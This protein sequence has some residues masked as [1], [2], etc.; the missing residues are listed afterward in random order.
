MNVL[1]INEHLILTTSKA[2]VRETLNENVQK[3]AFDYL[4][5]KAK[6]HSKVNDEVYEDLNGSQYLFDNRF[7][8]QKAKLLFMFRTRMFG[9]R[10]NFRNKYSCTLCPL[11]G[12]VEDSQEHLFHCKIVQ[13]YFVPST[14]YNNIFSNDVSCLLKVANELE[15]I[16]RIREELCPN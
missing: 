16:V 10:N 14:S 15:E 9:V 7:T 6:T 5:K 2:R 12:M 13:N 8:S 4:I 3:E 1:G 11:C